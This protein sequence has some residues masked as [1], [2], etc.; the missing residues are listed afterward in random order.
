[1]E[2]KQLYLACFFLYQIGWH[3]KQTTIHFFD[4]VLDSEG[5]FSHV[6]TILILNYELF[7]NTGDSTLFNRY[8]IQMGRLFNCYGFIQYCRFISMYSHGKVLNFFPVLVSEIEDCL[9]F[10]YFSLPLC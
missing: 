7:L 8:V 10:P 5:S 4:L 9:S 1:M 6:L 3:E 2:V